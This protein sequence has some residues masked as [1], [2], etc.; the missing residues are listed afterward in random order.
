MH[1]GFIFHTHIVTMDKHNYHS[2]KYIVGDHIVIYTGWAK[3]CSRIIL[4]TLYIQRGGHWVTDSKFYLKTRS[5]LV[6]WR[7]VWST[8][9]LEYPGYIKKV[10]MWILLYTMLYV[11]HTLYKTIICCRFGN[12][13]IHLPNMYTFMHLKCKLC[14]LVTK[15]V[16]FFC[17]NMRN[18]DHLVYFTMWT[19][20]EQFQ[21]LFKSRMS[22]YILIS[23][24]G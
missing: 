2:L 24:F 23:Y 12:F 8:Y 15:V 11:K 14:W 20:S 16:A 18:L 22:W 1:T 13:V 9:W 3:W 17:W 4:T 10:K 7:L 6:D 19:L 5:C 21:F